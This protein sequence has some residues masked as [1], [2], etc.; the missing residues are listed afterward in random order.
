M[1]FIETFIFPPPPYSSKFSSPPPYDWVMGCGV[2]CYYNHCD[3]ATELQIWAFLFH[4]F[5]YFT[6]PPQTG[7]L[8]PINSIQMT[9]KA[10]QPSI[11]LLS[12][13]SNSQV[14]KGLWFKILQITIS[15][16]FPFGSKNGWNI[17]IFWGFIKNSVF[18]WTENE[19]PLLIGYQ[20]P[21]HFLN[22]PPSLVT[23]IIIY[24]NSLRHVI[25]LILFFKCQPEELNLIYYV[26]VFKKSVPIQQK[27]YAG[28]LGAVLPKRLA[29]L[30]LFCCFYPFCVSPQILAN[31][32]DSGLFVLHTT[33]NV[34]PTPTPDKGVPIKCQHYHV[35]NIRHPQW[36][37]Y[38]PRN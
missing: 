1:L 16:I 17:D 32:V 20:D 18:I 37:P 27:K 8:I 15:Y 33:F 6:P 31:R 2:V 23:L 36:P 19:S 13:D 9:A 26:V 12:D 11:Y 30:C 35:P 29:R 3:A 24:R 34:Y 28:V 10:I 5:S 22:L 38:S 25:T 14:L 21:P 4:K 7:L